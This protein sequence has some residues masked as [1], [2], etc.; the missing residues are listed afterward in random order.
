MIARLDVERVHWIGTSMGGLI[1]LFLA[2]AERSPLK[3]RIHFTGYVEESDLL[4][5]YNAC[6]IFVFPSF[7][8]GFGLPILEAMACG[9]AVAC[10]HA[11]AM[12]E[13]A[14]S[15]GLM[16]DPNRTGE[17]TRAMR[18]LLIDDEL[19]TRMERLGQ[20]NAARFSWEK[21]AR[22]TLEVYYEVAGDRRR[23]EARPARSVPVPHS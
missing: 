21:T 12:L 5:L 2:A 16:F 11:A 20:Q 3:A 22:R 19:R 1:G 14:D 17:M 8:E 9:R 18:D 10:S 15:A 6:E 23:V 4:Y 13:V 7:Y